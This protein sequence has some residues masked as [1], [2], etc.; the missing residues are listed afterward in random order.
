MT[1]HGKTSYETVTF[2]IHHSKNHIKIVVLTSGCS[3]GSSLCGVIFI[4]VV[5]TLVKTVSELK[6]VFRCFHWCDFRVFLVFIYHSKT[7][8]KIVVFPV[9]WFE[10]L[11]LMSHVL[12]FL[13]IH[14]LGAHLGW[15]LSSGALLCNSDSTRSS[16][17]RRFLLLGWCLIAIQ[18]LVTL[19]L[20]YD[21]L[22]QRARIQQAKILWRSST[23][24]S[25]PRIDS[26]AC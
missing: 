14:G 20:S 11:C 9:S 22:F 6:G 26:T 17:F 4:K 1:S 3:H 8:I 15:I 19:F 7:R 21:I 13:T 16:D 12:V 24:D 18:F 5:K 10:A 2:E 23:P 25:P